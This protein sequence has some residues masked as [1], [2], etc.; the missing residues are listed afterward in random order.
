MKFNFQFLKI[1]L[2]IFDRNVYIFSMIRKKLLTNC[3]VCGGELEITELRCKRCGTVIRG[4]F[5]SCEFCNLNEDHLDF[6]RLFL[7][8]RG[9]LSEV[10]KRLGVSH[11]TARQRLR[12]LLD[13][14]GY[15]IEEPEEIGPSDEAIDLLEKGE[16]S[17]DEAIE[18][19][20]RRSKHE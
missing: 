9:N 10:A 1:K 15:E 19:I 5:Q 20:R 8:V 7:K 13:A 14:L 18:M 3:P 4:R 16:I 11:P 12:E 17:V 6:L 2:D